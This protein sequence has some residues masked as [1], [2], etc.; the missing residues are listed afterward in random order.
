[1][2]NQSEVQSS[3]KRKDCKVEQWMSC[4]FNPTLE[5][6]NKT[7]CGTCGW[8]PEV[9]RKRVQ[10]LD[11]TGARRLK[12]AAKPE[13]KKAGKNKTP[14]AA[15]QQPADTET[16]AIKQET[17]EPPVDPVKLGDIVTRQVSIIGNG[18]VVLEGR[19]VYIHP[20]WRFHVVEFAVGERVVTECFDGVSK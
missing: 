15:T 10:A 3:R 1:M 4:K 2:S 6:E 17:P 18:E 8:N 12:P 19:V 5:C 9:A 20:L 16:E 7:L 11:V 14:K 13:K